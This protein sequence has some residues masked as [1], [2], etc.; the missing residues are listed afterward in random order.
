MRHVGPHAL[1]DA[2]V[3]AVLRHEQDGH[4]AGHRDDE[5]G[6]EERGRA[7][8]VE[9]EPAPDQR[10]R[11]RDPAKDVLHAL[12]PAEHAVGQDVRVQAAVRR[13]VDVVGEEERRRASAPSSRGSA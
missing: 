2:A 1:E 6:D 3:A 8:E 7:P 10:T 5:R 11:E 12:R 13:L 9:E 4:G